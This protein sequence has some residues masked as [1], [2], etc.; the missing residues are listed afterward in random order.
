MNRCPQTHPRTPSLTER[1]ALGAGAAGAGRKGQVF[2]G[3][4]RSPCPC[5]GL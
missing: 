4:D 2:T 3:A 1:G 5:E